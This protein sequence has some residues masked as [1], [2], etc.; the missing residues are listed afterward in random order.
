METDGHER[1]DIDLTGVEA[2]DL[3]AL[4]PVAD[5][6]QF[7]AI[8]A[9][10]VDRARAELSRRGR[11]TAG[12]GSTLRHWGRVAWPAA[13]AV[14]LASLAVLRTEAP[15]MA[16]TVEVTIAEEM[17]LAVGVP[18]ALAPWVDEVDAPALGEILVGWDE[19]AR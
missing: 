9:E 15:A 2:V 12:V 7:D 10:I 17:A 14:A 11:R 6:E 16:A 18:E 13:A 5:G 3:S 19:G 1:H 8:V 4:D